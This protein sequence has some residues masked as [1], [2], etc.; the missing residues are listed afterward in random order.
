MK[1]TNLLRF[2]TLVFASLSVLITACSSKADEIIIDEEKVIEL[3]EKNA[4]GRAFEKEPFWFDE[5][6]YTGKPLSSKWKYDIGGGGWYNNEKQYYTNLLENV[7]VEDGVL[8]ITALK[9][10][11]GAEN[12]TSGKITTQ[13]KLDFLYGR[14]EAKLKV[15]AG[16]GTWPALWMLASEN[17]YGYWPNSGEIDIMEHVG[18]QPNWMHMT[19]H[20]FA[21]NAKENQDLVV[22]N[23]IKI[24]T[25]ISDFH[26]YRVDWTPEAI[27]GY[28]D[29][30]LLLEYKNDGKGD[31]KTWPF[32]KK[33]YLL[34][35][36]A[37]G[38]DWGGIEGIDDTVFPATYEVDYI[39]VHKMAE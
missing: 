31:Y 23:S 38:G 13:G 8:K 17:A 24:L 16:K 5:F 9:Q 22:N 10:T 20:N 35:N 11:I 37:I 29:D 7:R 2:F 32:D 3:T 26:V 19:I 28:I 25:S 27:R 18:Y 4:E 30:K 34:V 36:L 1:T 12:Y 6:D 15:P 39:R 21:G 14:V 33:F